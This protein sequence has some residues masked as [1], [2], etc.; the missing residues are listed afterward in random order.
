MD[1]KKMAADL[2]KQAALFEADAAKLRRA[3]DVLAP[4]RMAKA[5]EAKAAKAA[6]RR[7]L[8]SGR[9]GNGSEPV[10]LP[11][12][13]AGRTSHPNDPDATAMRQSLVHSEG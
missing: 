6:E 5:R 7:T 13:T 11:L 9:Q 8:G 2:R 1:I 10:T 12:G 3:A 4:D